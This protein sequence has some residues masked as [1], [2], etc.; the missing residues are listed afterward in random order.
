MTATRTRPRAEGTRAGAGPTEGC[1]DACWATP[2]DLVDAA[3]P[4]AAAAPGP[5]ESAA[6]VVRGMA[7]VLGCWGVVLIGGHFLWGWPQALTAV[8][9]AFWALALGCGRVRPRAA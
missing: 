9:L 7:T 3:G 2:G 5:P 1:A 6:G 4:G 8:G